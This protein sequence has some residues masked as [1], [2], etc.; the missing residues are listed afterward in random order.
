MKQT[1]AL[2]VE[3]IDECSL[4]E[5]LLI[6]AAA[7]LAVSMLFVSLA[8]DPLTA[9]RKA[10]LATLQ[11]HEARMEAARLQVQT[12]V[13]EAARDPDALLKQ[14]L[15][16]LQQQALAA[17]TKLDTL[18]QTLVSAEKMGEVL[19]GL[20]VQHRNVRLI[21]LK[22]LPPAGI[23]ADGKLVSGDASP[24]VYRQGVEI[25]VEGTFPDLLAYVEAIEASPWRLLWARTR[26]TVEE[27]PRSRLTLTLFTLSRDK[28]WLT[29]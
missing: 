7:A 24:L 16:E 19:R 18:A 22:N 4:R 27:Y 25:T 9:K 11:E 8:L 23:G 21:A 15:A 12:L 5:R 20:L 3:R 1:L 26:L 17:Q 14:R 6:F 2:W 13:K 10:L 29:V 28:P